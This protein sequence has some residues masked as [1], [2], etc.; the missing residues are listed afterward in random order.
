MGPVAPVEAIGE[1]RQ[2][3]FAVLGMNPM[4]GRQQEPLQV[5]GQGIYPFQ[6]FFGFLGMGAIRGLLELIAFGANAQIR[7]RRV[8]FELAPLLD[9][10]HSS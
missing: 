6:M 9:Q 8:R 5:G 4:V 2:V 7:R 1:F 10:F 3:G